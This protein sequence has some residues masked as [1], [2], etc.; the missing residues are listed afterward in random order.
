MLEQIMFMREVH[1]E[2]FLL[3]VFLIAASIGSFLN[4]VIYRLPKI[5]DYN[6]T[7]DAEAF[8]NHKGI[9]YKKFKLPDSKPSLNGSSH[10]P[11]CSSKIPLYYNIPILGWMILRGKTSC[12]KNKLSFRYPFIEIFIATASTL[13][14]Y[15]FSI[16]YAIISSVSIMILTC[17]FFIDKDNQIIPDSL[18]ALFFISTVLFSGFSEKIDTFTMLLDMIK[19][20]SL[21]LLFSKTFS[22][23]RKKEGL[24]LGDIKLISILAGLIGFIYLPVLMLVAVFTS[25]A[26]IITSSVKE[27]DSK[28]GVSGAIAFGPAIA[29]SGILLIAFDICLKYIY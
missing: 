16:D 6:W 22:L 5:M 17:I 23:I 12:C 25:L 8:L 15:F 11:T 19:T 13:C 14:F 26:L 4:V 3:F 9:K 29:V 1:N 27:D 28:F 21:L 24:G 10:C 18:L 20:L 7:L 2:T